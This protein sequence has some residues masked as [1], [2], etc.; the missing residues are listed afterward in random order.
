MNYSDVLLT[1]LTFLGHN[2]VS[3]FKFKSQITL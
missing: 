2:K 3:K 1:F